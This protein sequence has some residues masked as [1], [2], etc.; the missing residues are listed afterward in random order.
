M[1]NL[2]ELLENK[3]K[4]AAEI[5]RQAELVNK[6]GRDFTAEEKP[7]W[8]KINADYDANE[9]QIEIAKRAAVVNA[10]VGDCDTGLG[11]K[12]GRDDRVGDPNPEGRSIEIT[13][14]TRSL[15]FNAWARAQF[16]VEPNEE[17]VEACRALRFNPRTQEL[18]I[19]LLN[20]SDRRDLQ[21]TFRNTH[22]SRQH[23]I[24]FESRAMSAYTATTGGYLVP[25]VQF[26]RQ[27]EINMLAFGGME[28]V[29]EII[30]TSG[31]EPL[32]WP[33]AD[34][35]SNTGTQLAE[36]TSIGSSVEPSF[37]KVIFNAYKFSSKA[38]LVPYEL[39]QDSAF[40]VAGMLGAMLGERLGRITNTRATTGTGAGTF[41][42]ITNCT[43]LGVTAASATAIACD[44]VLNLVHSVDPAYRNGGRFMFHDGIL[45][46]LRKLK[47]GEGRYLWQQGVGS[48]PDSLWGYPY[49][50]N[51]DMQSTV[52]TGTKTIIFGQL[53]KY[54]IRRAGGVRLYRMQERYRDT[55]QDG[56]V[57]FLRQDG[58]LLQAGTAPVKHLIQA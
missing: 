11:V 55:D 28:Q 7:A 29:S 40:D 36:N 43:T 53:S 23:E 42:G 38:V 18:Q 56:F 51:Q 22:P 4:L 21:R 14:K 35:T 27:L 3:G 45:L 41:K 48:A 34:D 6:D 25:P 49:T 5:K 26:Q 24:K 20:D 1:P 33:T 52:A 37:A 16:G 31:G 44:E 2:K 13:D 50:I 15:A 10:S 19:P 54:K 17:A 30:T 46:Y 58:N 32:E 9:R 47:D 57:A 39:L 12:P 8:E